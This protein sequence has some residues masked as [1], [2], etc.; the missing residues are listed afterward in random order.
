MGF[1]CMCGRDRCCLAAK[2]SCW[3]AV[4]V[5]LSS[6]FS[7][8]H[9]PWW[10]SRGSSGWSPAADNKPTGK[11]NGEECLLVLEQQTCTC[12][13][14]KRGSEK[15]TKQKKINKKYKDQTF[16]NLLSLCFRWDKPCNINAGL[17][18]NPAHTQKQTQKKNKSN[19]QLFW[20]TS[21]LKYGSGIQSFLLQ[22]PQI[23]GKQKNNPDKAAWHWHASSTAIL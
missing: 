19:E 17:Y 13:D 5:L 9:L 7:L 20:L 22:K 23:R 15:A 3:E 8:T 1:I 6:L 12:S 18:V 4:V 21:N 14:N 11:I 10:L 2:R 16:G